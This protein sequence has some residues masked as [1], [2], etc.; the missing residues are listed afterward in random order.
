VED[1]GLV[2]VYDTASVHGCHKANLSAQNLIDNPSNTPQY[3]VL[4]V[5][6]MLRLGQQ[7]FE[8][9]P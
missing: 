5:R 2:E 3:L 4:E 6:P 7:H 8:T 1:F 9:G